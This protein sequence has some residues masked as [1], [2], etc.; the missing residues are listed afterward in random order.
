M[1]G[2]SSATLEPMAPTMSSVRAVRALIV[3]AIVALGCRAK[4]RMPPPS[5]ED[6]DTA[7]LQDGSETTAVET[8]AQ[9][10]TSSLLAASPGASLSLESTS[11]DLGIQTFGDAPRAVYFPRG[12]LDVTA[13]DAS[14][15]DTAVY[16]FTR[17][18]GPNGL[19]GVTGQVKA[20]STT[21]A[22]GSL[23]LE[24]TASE[25]SVNK[26]TIDWA[27]TAVV[28][29]TPDGVR[30]MTWAAQLSGTTARGRAF[31][32]MTAYTITWK[33]G[34]ACFALDGT[35]NGQV[36]GREL[37]TEIQG[38]RR[39]RRGCPD[40][41]KILVTNVEKDRTFELA[42]DGSS[43]ATFTGPNGRRSTI[44]LLCAQ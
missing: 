34:E 8:D 36:N 5:A 40:A 38:F 4:D 32:R 3:T 9:L 19:R 25:L 43:Q 21:E 23:H 28:S 42:Y 15:G 44:A 13:P 22:D 18:I 41:G 33:P 37:R 10:V 12:C 24:L 16:E 31:M 14:N 6:E 39:C 26:A 2:T 17:C 1:H 7:T 30:R 27:A 29:V 20:R 11:G 35:A